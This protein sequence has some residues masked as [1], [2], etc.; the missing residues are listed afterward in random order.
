MRYIIHITTHQ[1]PVRFFAKGLTREE[2]HEEG[3]EYICRL[4]LT[5]SNQPCGLRIDESH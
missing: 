1:E 5:A 2:A 4:P 3:L